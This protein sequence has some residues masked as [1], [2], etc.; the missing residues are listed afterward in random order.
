M[1]SRLHVRTRSLQ[2]RQRLRKKTKTTKQ[3][4][5]LLHTFERQ[6]L[7]K[8]LNLVCHG[9]GLS[10]HCD[11]PVVPTLRRPFTFV[12]NAVVKWKDFFWKNEKE[13]EWFSD[14]QL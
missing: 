12:W 13:R 7:H 14:S 8:W 11:A 2:P 9:R 4:I 1:R 3:V 5:Q 6:Q 10:W